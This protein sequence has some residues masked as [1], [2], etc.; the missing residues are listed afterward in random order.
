MTTIMGSLIGTLLKF[1]FFILVA[2]GG[3]VA[4]KKFRD[5]KDQKK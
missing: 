5:S 2:W 1:V 3:I 4:G